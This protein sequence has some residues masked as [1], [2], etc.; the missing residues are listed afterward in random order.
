MKKLIVI[1]VVLAVAAGGYFAYQKYFNSDDLVKSIPQDAV[2][3]G[4]LDLKSIVEKA[5]GK[6]LADMKMMQRLHDELAKDNEPVS[7]VALG[8]MDDPM[9][10]GI[11]FLK[12]VYFFVD[13]KDDN[14]IVGFTCGLINSEDFEAMM[15]KFPM[16]DTMKQN[17]EFKS[18]NFE[19]H[20]LFTWNQKQ[21][22]ILGS[23]KQA[24]LGDYVKSLFDH[25]NPN[26]TAANGFHD[27]NSSKFD[28]GMFMNYSSLFDFSKIMHWPASAAVPAD[29][30]KGMHAGAFTEFKDN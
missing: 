6:E 12:R 9:K 26:I 13:R 28:M 25:S 16:T 3:V 21:L 11:N 2:F 30:Y 24:A 7:K 18:M 8:L 23:D 27:F 10:T 5:G 1:L 29:L 17:G 19:G 20:L 14:E 22:I 15:K 4:V